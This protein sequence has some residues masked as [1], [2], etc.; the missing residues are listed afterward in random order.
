MGTATKVPQSRT[1]SGEELSAD[2]AWHTLRHT[3]AGQ[4]LRDAFLRFRSGPNWDEFLH[5]QAAGILAADHPGRRPRP[6][7]LAGIATLPVL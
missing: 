5:T 6:V 2:D 7:R 4:L 3:G 1:M